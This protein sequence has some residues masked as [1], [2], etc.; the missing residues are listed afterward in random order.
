M[1]EE[2]GFVIVEAAINN[3]YVISSDCPN[4]PRD[5]LNDGKNG[6]LF[7]NNTKDEIYKSL[8][9]FESFSVDKKFRD[10]VILKEFKNLF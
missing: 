8:L 1:W 3:L 7:Q 6:I 9:K 10:K 5:F 4:G 2:V